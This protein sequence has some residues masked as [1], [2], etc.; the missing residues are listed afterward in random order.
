M[1]VLLLFSALLAIPGL[2]LQAEET[3]QV[4]RQ[5]I[6]T[7]EEAGNHSAALPLYEQLREK[8]PDDSTLVHQYARTLVVVG[9]HDHIVH[10]LRSWLKEHPE[11]VQGHLRL[12]RAFVEMQEDRKAIEAWRQ[13]LAQAPHRTRLYQKVSNLCRQAGLESEA[14]RILTEGREKLGSPLLFSWELADLYL[15]IE[16]FEA[17]IAAYED[18]LTEAPNRYASVEHRL[19]SLARDPNVAALILRAVEKMRRSTKVDRTEGNLS[20]LLRLEAACALEAGKPGRAL[21]LLAEIRVADAPRLLHQ[22]AVRAER[23]GHAEEA[24]EAYRLSAEYPPD[25]ASR[26]TPVGYQSLLRLAALRAKMGQIPASVEIYVN[27]AGS[28]PSR[29]EAQQAMFELGRLQLQTQHDANGASESLEAVV[30]AAPRGPWVTKALRLLAECA[31][32]LDDLER[33]DARLQELIQLERSSAPRS[34]PA[35]QQAP[36]PAAAPELA[37]APDIQY[38][39]AEIAFFQH[40]FDTASNRIGRLL[41]RNTTDE[42]AN[43]A[44]ELSL[45][46]EAAGAQTESLETYANALLLERQRRSDEA[47]DAW[48]LLAASGPSALRQLGLLTRARQRV[49]A[50]EDAQAL[51]FY[52]KLLHLHSDS[53]HAAAA[54][55][56]RAEVYERRQLRKEALKT[57]ETALL[58]YP[59]DVRAPE[60]RLRIQ[61]LRRLENEETKG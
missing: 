45:L 35:P 18:H 59:E 32:R 25:T 31:L 52:E 22:F 56:G 24:A 48:D 30:R 38:F 47:A 7:L 3:T 10:L 28:F 36:E 6:R 51:A 49:F 23:L 39:R 20:N 14:V 57:Y 27:L 19:T 37:A 9:A 46:I 29:P 26:L 33:A 5:Q 50:G 12:G 42:M 44:L 58:K 21:R 17:A 53:P 4:L 1:I 40:D 2:T 13:A 60:I 54:L 15:R 8:T 11:D 16:D 34:I 55:V 43:D 61:R 41:S